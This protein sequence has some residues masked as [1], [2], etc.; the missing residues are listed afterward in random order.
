MSKPSFVLVVNPDLPDKTDAD[1]EVI[2]RFK[3]ELEKMNFAL[4]RLGEAKGWGG[5]P[6]W[7][8]IFEYGF[9]GAVNG[10]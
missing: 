7:D 5:N 2:E 3:L 8:L 6:R 1:K 4:E 9:K 10:K